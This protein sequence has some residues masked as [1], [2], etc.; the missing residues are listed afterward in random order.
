MVGSA[1]AADLGGAL[2]LEDICSH[3]PT[4]SP[5]GNR[6]LRVRYG[7]D[8]KSL[9]PFRSI[10]ARRRHHRC[11]GIA[12]S[13][14]GEATDMLADRFRRPASWCYIP[15]RR[16]S[17]TAS[18]RLNRRGDFP[19]QSFDFLGFHLSE[20][21]DVAKVIAPRTASCPP[22]AR[23]HSRPSAGQS[24]GERFISAVTSPCRT[25][26]TCTIRTL[27]AGSTTTAN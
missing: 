17:S 2:G 7:R 27:E 8:E 9:T 15:R 26:P 6:G 22:P 24:D 23:R 3:R 16:R 21:N 5:I 14:R 20:E 12:D 11:R 19:N 18:V 13:A 10:G 25:W 4:A 1:T